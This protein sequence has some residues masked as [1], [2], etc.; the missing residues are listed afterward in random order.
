M[1]DHP[2]TPDPIREY[3][4]SQGLESVLNTGINKVLREKPSDALSALAVYLME[5]AE[6]KPIFNKFEC[7]ITLKSFNT[8]VYLDF[9][10]QTK[11][12]HTHIFT[13]DSDIA[14]DSEDSQN[15]LNGNIKAAIE[16]IHNDLNNILSGAD[17]SLIK[18][19]DTTLKKFYQDN[20]EAPPAA[21]GEEQKED[22]NA[23]V[24]KIIVKTCSEAL[25]HAIVKCYDDFETYN[26]YA[27][28]LTGS[29]I[30]PLSIPKLMFSLLNGGKS[31]NSKVKFSKIYLIFGAVPHDPTDML[32]QFSKLRKDIT[33]AISGSK[34]GLAGFKVGPDGVY[35]NA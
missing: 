4:T 11:C 5:N 33:A 19:T 9:G 6:K 15:E 1:T 22:S 12:R 10:G 2:L 21:E 30:D 3:I 13:Y 24:G 14:N 8:H 23:V 26:A 27:Q 34:A 25:L 20:F 29:Q 17:L 7:E 16:Y 31:A 28:F 18:K 32:E 35:F